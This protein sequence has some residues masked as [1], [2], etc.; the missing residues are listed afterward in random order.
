MCLMPMTNYICPLC[1]IHMIEESNILKQVEHKEER[2]PESSLNEDS[3]IY[4]IV[5][6]ELIVKKKT[7]NYIH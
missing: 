2:S 5:T 1:L 6:K 4:D 7:T 3:T